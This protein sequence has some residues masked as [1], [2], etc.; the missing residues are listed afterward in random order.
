M[1]ILVLCINI[2]I[3]ITSCSD[4]KVCKSFDLK[5]V[6]YDTSYYYSS[7]KYISNLDTIELKRGDTYISD[8]TNWGELG[9][10]CNPR[11]E[12]RHSREDNRFFILYSFEYFDNQNGNDSTYLSVMINDFIVELNLDTIKNR[13][14][15]SIFID[16]IENIGKSKFSNK[17]KSVL[18]KRMKI[19]EMVFEDGTVY[20]LIP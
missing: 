16:K 6:F 17:L 18:F 9:Y 7:L 13:L 2:A 10:D 4:K 1:K 8:E 3:I 5:R 20:T 14:N 12:I 11:F 15:E 19:I